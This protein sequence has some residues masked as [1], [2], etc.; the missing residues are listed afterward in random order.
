M[1]PEPEIS[2]VIPTRRRPQFLPRSV[3]A[4]LHQDEP[5]PFEVIV[6]NDDD[7]PIG[8]SLPDDPRVRVVESRSPGVTSARNTGIAAARAPIVAFTDDDTNVTSGW[9]AAIQRAFADHPEALGVEGPVV[10]GRE[11]DFLYEHVPAP[12]LPGGFC[13][14]NV[15]YRVEAI[16]GVGGFDERFRVAGGEDIDLGLRIAARGDVIVVPDMVVE[17]PPRPMGY[18]EHVR[19]GRQV[20]NEW[21]LHSKHPDLAGHR[22]P[23]RWGPVTSRA[24]GYARMLRDPSITRGSPARALRV[25]ALGAGTAAVA[26]VTACNSWPGPSATDGNA[27]A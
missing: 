1:A 19:Q 9:L 25:V 20:Q 8:C 15:A 10:Y 12:V 14:C 17:H 7:A 22:L 13:T 27:P 23:L 2:V 24:R 18:L 6:V 5:P 16:A 21:L 26:F 11:P 4:V 3:A